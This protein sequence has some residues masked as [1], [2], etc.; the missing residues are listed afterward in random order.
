MTAPMS[1]LPATLADLVSPLTEPELMGLLRRR[2]LAYRPCANGDHY[3]PMLGWSALRSMIEAGN[4]FEKRRELM[5]Q[6][7]AYC[8][9][10]AP[11]G[12]VV[13][14]ADARNSA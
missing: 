8:T 11:A 3:A 6:W 9:G 12:E 5:R 1:K 13:S 10:P 4:F 14:L 7:G 2:E